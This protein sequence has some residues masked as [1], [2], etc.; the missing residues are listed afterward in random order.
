M[1]PLYVVLG[2]I[3]V[4]VILAAFGRAGATPPPANLSDEQIRRTAAQGQKIQAIKWYRT[5]HGVGLK[6]AK[7]AVEAMLKKP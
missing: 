4:L 2:I 6:E 3:V 7:D 1:T 5:L